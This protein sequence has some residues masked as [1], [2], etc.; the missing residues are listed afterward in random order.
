MSR[1]LEKIRRVINETLTKGI[2]TNDSLTARELVES[3][4]K[5]GKLFSYKGMF[6]ASSKTTRKSQE[7]LRTVFVLKE[8]DSGKVQN[9]EKIMQIVTDLEVIL[10]YVDNCDQ[11]ELEGFIYLDV[12]KKLEEEDD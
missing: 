4:E 1:Q 3:C 8:G 10:E 9:V 2:I 5:E 7:C 11:T 12:I 6:I